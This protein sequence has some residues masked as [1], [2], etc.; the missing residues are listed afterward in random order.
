MPARISEDEPPDWPF[1]SL[2]QGK[3]SELGP[4]WYIRDS[5]ED[6]D[7]AEPGWWYAW[8]KVHSGH[9]PSDGFLYD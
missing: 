9:G 4:E 2:K 7:D 8:M 3:K 5:D 6:D 1:P